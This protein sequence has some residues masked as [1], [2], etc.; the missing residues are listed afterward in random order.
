MDLSGVELVDLAERESLLGRATGAIRARFDEQCPEPTG[1]LLAS[2]LMAAANR[3]DPAAAS[4]DLERAAAVAEEAGNAVLAESARG[5]RLLLLAPAAAETALEAVAD[6]VAALGDAEGHSF[7]LLRLATAH[8]ARQDFR[9]AREVL[10]RAETPIHATGKPELAGL[11]L[12]RQAVLSANLGD[13]PRAIELAAEAAAHYTEAGSPERTAH[14]RLLAA[15]FRRSLGD[16][17]GAFAATTGIDA[18]T[19]LGIQA[20]V[21]RFRGRLARR[22]DRPDDAIVAFNSA[23]ADFTA[24]EQPVDA[25]ATRVD[26]ARVYL[27]LDRPEDAAAAV[28]DAEPVLARAGAERE[29]ANGRSLLGHAYRALGRPA[30]AAALFGE[31]AAYF[32]V[33]SPAAA[34]EAREALADVLTELDRDAEAAA[35][36]TRAAGHFEQAGLRAAELRALRRP[37]SAWLRSGDADRTLT[38]LA[39]ADAAESDPTDPDAAWEHAMTTFDGA[40]VLSELGHPEAA[41]ARA[42]TAAAELRAIDATPMIVVAEFLCGQLLVELGKFAEAREKLTETLALLPEDAGRKRRDVEALLA[43]LPD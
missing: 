9:G 5:A 16:V 12:A 42:T 18:G 14:A 15:R 19:D 25:A 38:A 7:A 41:Y 33:A 17:E 13:F 31:A 6:R 1:E 36:Y 30:Q 2:R 11:W 24:A 21:G 37:P 3:D 27:D 26:L 28:T 8:F 39:T 35:D 4:R 29:Q 10:D 22:L 43:D 40:R 23:I 34:G 20:Q 32:A